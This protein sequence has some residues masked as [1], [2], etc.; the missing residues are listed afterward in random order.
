MEE[1]GADRRRTR[2]YWQITILPAV[3]NEMTP[4][5]S[6][7]ERNPGDIIPMDHETDDAFQSSQQNVH[8]AE[9]LRQLFLA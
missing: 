1:E 6:F 3:T 4:G 2:G 9:T 7:H 5:Y 8:P